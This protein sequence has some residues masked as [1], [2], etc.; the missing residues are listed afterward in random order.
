MG[1][2]RFLALVVRLAGL[3]AFLALLGFITGPLQARA[4][5]P[6]G[7]GE[8]AA[9]AATLGVVPWILDLGV[10]G[11]ITRQRAQGAPAGVLYGSTVPLAILSSGIAV[12]LAIPLAHALGGG[13]R[14]A[15]L[16][17][18]IG[19]F[20][21]PFAVVAQTMAGAVVGEERWRLFTATRLIANGGSAIGIVVL[22]LINEL[23]VT[24]AA[25]TILVTSALQN[26]VML[27]VARGS[28]PWRFSAPVA[29]AA[30]VFGAR[31]WPATVATAGTL[32][33][34]Q[35]LMA[36]LVPTRELGLYAI[37]VTAASVVNLLVSA[38]T[39]ALF[40]RIAAGQTE[41][42]APIVRST[43]VGLVAISAV[44]AVLA[45][46]LF[47]LL[48][49]TEFR[50]AVPMFIILLVAN[51]LQTTGAMLAAGLGAGGWPQDTLRAQLVGLGITIPALIVLLPSTGGVGAASISL[52]AYAAAAIIMLSAV[53]RRFGGSAFSYL[54][55]RRSDVTRV[56][57]AVAGLL[58]PREGLPS[59]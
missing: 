40:P 12:A 39:T 57:A 54:I 8:I 36:A 27:T 6:V 33:L 31:F 34:D 14:E 42:L 35:L 41:L 55:P 5:G 11:Y 10:A 52:A 7:R 24:T 32:R 58:A 51:I 30:L 43:T 29:K 37:A 23:T 2:H 49:G 4:L 56:R 3:N 1:R 50:A 21:M 28:W 48:F 59:E 15:V 45:R 18:E 53:V 19:L 46:P 22:Y 47:D 13:H 25:T 44:E 26:L 20:T 9:I 38:I 16:F 17:L